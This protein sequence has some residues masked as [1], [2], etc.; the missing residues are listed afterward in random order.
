MTLRRLLI[1][2]LL[3]G[4]LDSLA[5]AAGTTLASE[6]RVAPAITLTPENPLSFGVIDI[7]ITAPGY[8]EI[9]PVT[10][11]GSGVNAL[12]VGSASRGSF[13]VTGRSGINVTMTATASALTCDTSYLNPCQGSDPVI[14]NLVHTFGSQIDSGTCTGVRCTE[15]VYVGARIGFAGTERGRWRGSIAVTANYQ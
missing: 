11:A 10:N 4:S 15:T 3:S 7:P 12:Q 8:Y 2:L 1:T 5:Y 13:L 9:D 6:A 14:T